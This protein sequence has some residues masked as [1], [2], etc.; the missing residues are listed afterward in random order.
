MT[1]ETSNTAGE[2][3]LRTQTG[4]VVSNKLLGRVLEH[5]R[6][7]QIVAEEERIQAARV[8]RLRRTA[9]KRLMAARK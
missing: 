4:T 5:A 8:K 2:T 7:L 6:D 3:K 1:E 9:S